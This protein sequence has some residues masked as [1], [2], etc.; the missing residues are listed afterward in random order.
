MRTNLSPALALLPLC[1]LLPPLG[2]SGKDTGSGDADTDSDTDADSD[3]D[4]D[5][6]TDVPVDEDHDGYDSDVDCNDNNYQ[7]YP[8]APEACN[9][10][11]DDCD[12]LT[13]EDFDADADGEMDAGACDGGTDCNDADDTIGTTLPEIPYDGIDQDCDGEDETDVDGDFY[14]GGSGTDCD[15]T[16]PD[17]HP[18]ATEIA[19][20]GIDQDCDGEDA[21]DGDGDGYGDADLGGDDCDDLDPEVHPGV[22]DYWNDGLDT[23]CD[24]LDNNVASLSSASVAVSG[25]DGAQELAGEDVALCDLDGDTLLDLVV[26]AP[27]ADAYAGQVAIFYGANRADWTSTMTLTDADTLITS[28]SLFL[29]FELGCADLDADGNNDLVTGRGEIH[30]STYQ[31]D[32]ELDV[33]YGT[34]STWP[35]TMSERDGDAVF[36]MSIGVRR[37]LTSVYG[38]NFTLADLDGDGASEIV[39]MNPVDANLSGSDDS[40]YILGGGHYTGT[41]QLADEASAVITGE[42]I[43]TAI[44]LPDLDGDGASELFLGESQHAPED[45]ADTGYPGR[46]SFVNDD[47]ALGGGELG[48]LAYGFWQGVGS[49][50][51]GFAGATGDFDGDGLGDLAVGALG[52][53]TNAL[54]AG[55]LYLFAPADA[56]PDG[57]SASGAVVLGS[58]ASG[59][60]GYAVSTAGDVSG[61]GADDLLVSEP[62]ADSTNGR[63]WLLDGAA[64][65][66]SSVPDDSAILAWTGEAAA[67]LTGNALAVGDLDDDGL[68]DYVIGAYAYASD[69]TNANGKVYVV[70]SGG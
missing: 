9:G 21:I 46:A 66:G 14:A 15:D 13:D 2:C 7:V 40:Y 43:S 32:F 65:L 33:W 24:G 54:F 61:D 3:A 16:D 48:S 56:A 67:S 47:V 34:G 19:K 18:G 36:E 44:E 22:I 27:F 50:Q 59:Y 20:D 12:E 37:N 31:T 10:V 6:D 41:Y 35:A 60:L 11:D 63:V 64:A 8:G 45:S 25:A 57:S 5:T 23:D 49:E 29:G 53:S 62:Q 38:R 70:L 42:G 4:S 68:V 52:E 17:V 28:D 1:L 26:A 58:T 39:L 51:L 55:G 30:Y 69:G